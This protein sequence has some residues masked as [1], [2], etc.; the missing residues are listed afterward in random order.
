[1]Q[2]TLSVLGI[3]TWRRCIISTT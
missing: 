2:S 3:C 1:M